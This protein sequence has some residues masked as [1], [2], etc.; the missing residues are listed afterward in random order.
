MLPAVRGVGEVLVFND[1]QLVLVGEKFLWL[2]C[3][4]RAILSSPCCNSDFSH[5]AGHVTWVSLWAHFVILLLMIHTQI[6]VHVLQHISDLPLR[7]GKRT[8]RVPLIKKS[9]LTHDL[10]G[11][12]S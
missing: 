6:H 7:A 12:H 1:C 2:Y 8:D 3:D 11:R 4:Q 9:L 5:I 10:K